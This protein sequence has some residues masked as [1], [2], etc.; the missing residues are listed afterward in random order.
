MEFLDIASL[1]TAYRYALKIKHKFKQER[2]EFG[3]TNSSQ[4]KQGKDVPNQHNKWQSKY[5]HAHDN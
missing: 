3:S 2:R 1:G 5:G 4:Q